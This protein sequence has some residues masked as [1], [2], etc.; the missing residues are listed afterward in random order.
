MHDTYF[1]AVIRMPY[2]LSNL[3]CFYHAQKYWRSKLNIVDAVVAGVCIIAL[4]FYFMDPQ[5][6]IYGALSLAVSRLS[7][8]I[9]RETDRFAL[10][11]FFSHLIIC[12]RLVPAAVAVH[13]AVSSVGCDVK[14]PS[15]PQ[16]GGARHERR[17]LHRGVRQ[18]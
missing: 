6:V 4:F 7:R 15:G 13:S 12:C 9:T 16:E 2:H 10:I 3:S 5:T 14:E 11:T 18:P 8:L 17:L 1:R